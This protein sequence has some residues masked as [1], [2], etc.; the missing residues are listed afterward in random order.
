MDLSSG[1]N[2]N[3]WWCFAAFS[4]VGSGVALKAL[5]TA[6]IATNFGIRALPLATSIA[7]LALILL[8]FFWVKTATTSNPRISQRQVISLYSILLLVL[9]SLAWYIPACWWGWFCL[10]DLHSAIP[11]ALFWRAAHNHHSPTVAADWY[12]R[13]VIAGALGGLTTSTLIALLSH[14]LSFKLQAFFSIFICSTLLLL[15]SAIIAACTK[16][17][18]VSL[19]L[20]SS[21]S[22]YTAP[23]VSWSYITATT[24]LAI[25]YA[26]AKS[27]LDF[28]VART[29]HDHGFSLLT[30][31]SW[32]ETGLQIG[33]IALLFAVGTLKLGH[34]HLRLG[35][36][37]SPISMII[38]APLIFFAQSPFMVLAAA[39]LV[40]LSYEGISY[41]CRK[42]TLLLLPTKIRQNLGLLT[43]NG[44]RVTKAM[45]PWCAESF[46]LSYMSLALLMAAAIWCAW[47]VGNEY[48][49][50][51]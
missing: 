14:I 6:C 30:S 3:F 16:T 51:S 2:R 8:N 24:Y 5:K 39:S 27:I 28:H 23:T 9:F 17:G 26:L 32:Y 10:A 4:V 7:A 47:R 42:Q 36:L 43:L 45:G 1:K 11:L 15:T 46:P 29:L 13:Y 35:L 41:V 34:T 25:S 40:R 48:A 22:N 20:A 37:I 50:K 44:R 38:A 49:Q 19:P 12:P 18:V 21:P 31:L 33:V